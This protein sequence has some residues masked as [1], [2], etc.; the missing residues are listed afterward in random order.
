MYG[1]FMVFCPNCGKEIDGEYKFCPSCGKKMPD[2][3]EQ[4]ETQLQV[5]SKT[6]IDG[7]LSSLNDYYLLNEQMWDFGSGD[8]FNEKGHKIGEMHRIILSLRADIEL[9]EANG[10][11]A[12][13]VRR[14]IVA[15]RPTYDIFNKDMELVGRIKKTLTSVFRPAL[16]FEDAS[17]EKYLKAQGNFMKW[18]FDLFNLKDK[19][20]AEVRKADQWRDIFL[21]GVFDFSDKYALRIYDSEVDRLSLL[22]FVISV[23]NMFHDTSGGKNRGRTFFPK[24]F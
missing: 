10:E 2:L 12:G 22:A 11:I 6:E 1:D 18:N 16:W 23:D 4:S 15:I 20:I 24:P 13:K 5:K 3:N 7:L 9:K 14:K 17:G 8:I 21:G 19:K